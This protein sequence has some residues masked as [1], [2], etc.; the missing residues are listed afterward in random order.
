[1]VLHVL[2]WIACISLSYK[3]LKQ[4][5]KVFH[6]R[7]SSSAVTI[8]WGSLCFATRCLWFSDFTTE[9]RWL[10]PFATG[11]DISKMVRNWELGLF[12]FT[13]WRG[14]RTQ[15]WGLVGDSTLPAGA[16]NAGC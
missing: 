12:A 3:S 9:C 16:R 1:L 4:V 6:S 14:Q 5:R 13:A 8:L 7:M 10:F 2:I 15:T 11:C